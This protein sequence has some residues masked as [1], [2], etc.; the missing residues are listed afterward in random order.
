MFPRYVSCEGAVF[1]VMNAESHIT[2]TSNDMRLLLVPGPQVSDAGFHI[3]IQGIVVMVAK[4]RYTKH[5]RYGIEDF[6]E[7][8]ACRLQAACD[9]SRSRALQGACILVKDMF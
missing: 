4:L 8:H 3:L 6:V 9:A 1:R 2:F 5:L 7:T